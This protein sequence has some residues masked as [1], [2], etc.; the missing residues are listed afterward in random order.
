MDKWDGAVAARDRLFA[1]AREAKLANLVAV[2]GDV[3]HNCVGELKQDFSD[4]ASH[5]LGV[6]FVG[7]SITSGGDG[8]DTSA[9]FRALQQQNAHIKFYNGQRGYVRHIVNSQRWQA[10]YRV[11]DKIS[12]RDGN[13]STRMSFV[14]E[15]GKP[16]VSN[17]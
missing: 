10:D 1:A 12:V 7:T 5:T 3:H 13:V 8:S 4:M 2:T 16:G 17:A 6:E 11:L 14:V 9:R 15:D